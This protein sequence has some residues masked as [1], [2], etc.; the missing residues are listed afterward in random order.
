[1]QLSCEHPVS[2]LRFS[3]LECIGSGAHVDVVA[4]EMNRRVEQDIP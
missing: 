4:H 1:M 2:R 3:K